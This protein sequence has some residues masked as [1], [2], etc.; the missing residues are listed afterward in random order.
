MNTQEILFSHPHDHFN[1]RHITVIPNTCFVLMPFEDRFKIVYETIVKAL[2]G[3][4]VCT[5]ADDLPMGKPILEHI[6]TGIRSSEL[7]I[8]DLTGSNP[9]VFYELGFAHTQTKN[10]L[11]LTQNIDE[12]PFDLRGLFCHT[13]SYNSNHGLKCLSNAV[14]NAAKEIRMKS[15]PM[16]LQ[17]RLTRTKQIVEY[18]ERVE[19]T[20]KQK[21]LIV[22]IQAGI[23]SLSNIG[24]PDSTD[25]EEQEYGKWLDKEREILVRLIENGAMLQAIIHPPIGIGASKMKERWHQR[26]DRLI[27]FL[28]RTDL[29]D[30]A[31][32]VVSTEEG[33]N[34]FFFGEEILFEGHKTGIEGGYGWTMVY[35]DTNYLTARLTIFDMLF[36]SARRYT[37]EKYSS[38]N[39]I[40]DERKLLRYAVIKAINIAR[41]GI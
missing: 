25:K 8:A 32:F 21:G 11:L 30:S 36:Q 33:S 5:R 23:S 9:N 10:V 22:R 31:E 13:Y 18:M 17:G 19:S 38:G 14:R 35:T 7:I 24:Y 27:D 29:L 40:E 16:M 12:V 37:L 34:L 1:H 4:M 26:F 3:M 28:N 41:N 15:V 20:Q 39:S 2:K 6:L